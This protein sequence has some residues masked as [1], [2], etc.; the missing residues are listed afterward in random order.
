MMYFVQKHRLGQIR[1]VMMII[2]ITAAMAV[3]MVVF[4]FLYDSIPEIVRNSSNF[5]VWLS[6][7]TG[8]TVN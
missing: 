7:A 5:L 1:N 3:A 8:M 2:A 4:T 6:Q